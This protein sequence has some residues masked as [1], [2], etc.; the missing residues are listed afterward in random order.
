MLKLIGKRLKELFGNPSEETEFFEEL[1]EILIEGDFGARLAMKFVDEL[2]GKIDRRNLH[3]RD[4]LIERMK[5]LLSEELKVERLLPERGKLTVFL[6]FGVNGVGKTTTIAKLANYY[7]GRNYKV[8]LSAADTY[9]AAAIEQLVTWGER[10]GVRVIHQSPGSDPGAVVFDS[11][12]S[13]KRQ[14]T[15]LLIA[16]TAGRMHSRQDL[17][18]ELQKINKVV[19]SKIDKY[20]YRKILVIDA[21]TGQ[22]AYQQAEIF[23]E[24]VGI[25]SA[26]LAKYDSTAKGGVVFAI[27]SQLGIPFSFMGTGEGI[28]DIEEFEKDRFLGSLFGLT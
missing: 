15:E 9:R 6:V 26:I 25:D 16:D 23:N 5:G 8:M 28:D 1:E 14:G 27:S 3:E 21:T 12:D 4:L 17:V 20:D 11:I 2:K 7:K 22:N 24:A 10:V 18:R 13:A 19:L